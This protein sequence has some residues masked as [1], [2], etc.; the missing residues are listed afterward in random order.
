MDIESELTLSYYK[1]I[2]DIN[3]AHG[4]FLVQHT[5]NKRIY[6]KKVMS[7][8]NA[9]IYHHLKNHPISGLPFIHELV[10]ADGSL[11]IIEDYVAGE[12]L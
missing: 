8:Y 7:V 10:E 12:T 6:V 5:E 1:E 4:V 9:K 2:A 3:R 11:T